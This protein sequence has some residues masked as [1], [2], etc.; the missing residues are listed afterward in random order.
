MSPNIKQNRWQVGSNDFA[1]RITISDVQRFFDELPILGQVPKARSLVIEPGT[2]S[3]IIEDGALVGQLYSGE[4]TFET[5]VERLKFW[6]RKQATAFLTRMEDI[7]VVSSLRSLPCLEGVCFDLEC[8]WTVAINDVILFMENLMGAHE[9][10]SI[11]QLEEWLVPIVHQAIRDTLGQLDFGLLTGGNYLQILNDGV[12]KRVDVKFSRYGLS[13]VDLQSVDVTPQDG[14]VSQLK[15]QQW[16]AARENQLLRAA[17]EI[18][19]EKLAINANDMRQKVDL[20]VRLRGL[21]SEDNLNKLKNKEEF[22]RSIDELDRGRLLRTEEREQ[23]IAAYEERKEDRTSLRE[24]LLAT[25]DMQREQEIEEFRLA[26]D[27]AI[28][29][30][31][32]EQEIEQS[33]LGRTAEAETWRHELEKE[34]EVAQKHQEMQVERLKARWWNLREARRQKRDE[35]WEALLNAH[36]AEDTKAAVELSRANRQRQLAVVRAELESRLA[37]EKLEM[38]KRQELWEIEVR[39]KRSVSQLERMQRLQELNAQ[40]AERQLRLQAELETLKAEN[41][42]KLELERIRALSNVGTEVLIATSNQANAALLADLKKHEASQEAIKAQAALSPAETLNAERLK[43]YE[44]M[45]A[46]ERAKAE[47]IAEAYKTAMLAQSSSV[48]QMIGGL[49]QAARPPVQFQQPIPML[50]GGMVGSAPTGVG[51][52]YVNINGQSSPLPWAEFQ[53]L[54]RGGHI[55]PATMV[56]KAGMSN[57]VVAGQVPELVQLFPGSG[58]VPQPVSPASHPTA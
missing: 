27:H 50:V 12:R 43:M 15:G 54:I 40:F 3:I 5:F 36:R 4:Y 33:R 22:A 34:R 44:Q 6:R 47:A 7:P 28:R 21:V 25:L 35:S 52:W 24:H 51:V 20:R 46:T 49:S 29:M 48:N 37:H 32:L 17:N 16:L 26:M 11:S 57:W 39:D 18:D 23:L 56:W 53:E 45:N 41:V 14:G 31:R 19:N 9:A 8:R 10:V 1:V 55:T 42:G 30:K 58:M 13:F 38:Q 2:R